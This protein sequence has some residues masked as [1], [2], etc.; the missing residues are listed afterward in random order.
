MTRAPD[1]EVFYD[2]QCP[3]CRWE[4]RLYSR[5]DKNARV[6]WTDIEKLLPEDLPRGKTRGDLL[7]KFHVRDLN[8]ATAGENASQD[9]FVGV[10]AFARIWKV[11]PALRYFAGLFSVPGIRQLT[12]LAYRIFLKWQSWHRK[13]RVKP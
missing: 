7:G 5:M 12:M 13:R 9:W 1:I 11:L 10:D 4:V 3:I 2:G 6:C 8:G